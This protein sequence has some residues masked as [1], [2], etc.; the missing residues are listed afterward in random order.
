MFLMDFDS[1]RFEV[2]QAMKHE[3]EKGAKYTYGQS[4]NCTVP[5]ND[6]NLSVHRERL[7]PRKGFNTDQEESPEAD[8]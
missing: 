2:I 5:G 1:F 8:Q 3:R 4:T 6:G 7:D